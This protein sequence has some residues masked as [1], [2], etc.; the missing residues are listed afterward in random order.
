MESPLPS[1]FKGTY[2]WSQCTE[3]DEDGDLLVASFCGVEGLPVTQHDWV[4]LAHSLNY[5]HY[6]GN[7]LRTKYRDE[8]RA[9]PENA[10]HAQEIA[11]IAQEREN[12]WSSLRLPQAHLQ[13]LVY[14]K[15]KCRQWEAQEG[16]THWEKVYGITLG[17]LMAFASERP[18][19][20]SR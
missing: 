16:V 7:D 5:H 15:N 17:E 1:F 18:E 3:V 9:L 2:A 10:E 6:I 13:E 8:F 19:C 12:G 11:E 20:L 14:I 4:V